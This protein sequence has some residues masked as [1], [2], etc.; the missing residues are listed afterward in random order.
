MKSRLFSTAICVLAMMLAAAVSLAQDS[1]PVDPLEADADAEPELTWDSYKVKA[2]TIQIFGGVFGGDEYLN[3]PVTGDRTYLQDGSNLVMGYDGTWWETEELNY[4]HYRGPVKEL[5]DGN[6]FGVKVGAY[7]SGNFHLDLVL[8]YSSS[9][10]VLT[11]TNVEDPDNFVVEEIDRDPSVEIF[12]GSLQAIYDVNQ[13]D[14][15]G[16][17]P[18]LGFGFGGV[19]NR[20]SQLEDVNGLFLVGT[21]GLRRQVVGN[22]SAFVQFD[23]TNFSMDRDELHY[24]ESVTYTD[25]TAGISFYLDT[26]PS[27]IRAMHAAD[28]ADRA[29]RR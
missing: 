9:E 10:A 23:L 25:I 24:T 22:A 14:L 2:Y 21:I 27:D 4:D 7:L 6:T 16:I 19:I 13:V 12:R 5:E 17:E 26:V 18:Y 1:A 20:F 15:F 8:A 3:L 28:V 29:R 11:M